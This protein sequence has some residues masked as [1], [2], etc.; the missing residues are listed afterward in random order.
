MEFEAYFLK[1]FIVILKQHPIISR[2]WSM[3]FPYTLLCFSFIFLL[4][5]DTVPTANKINGVNFVAPSRVVRSN[6]MTP[7]VDV[8]A[9]W[10]SVMPY[11]YSNRRSPGVRHNTPWQWW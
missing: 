3:K 5:F 9:G 7:V 8:G 2:F 11:A 1:F 10:I 6:P 4:A